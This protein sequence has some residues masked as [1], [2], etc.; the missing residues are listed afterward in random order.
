M[1]YIQLNENGPG[2]AS[3]DLTGLAIGA[4]YTLSFNYWGD[5]EPGQPYQLT[6][7][8]DGTNIFS[9]PT[10]YDQ[11]SGYYGGIGI[12]ASVIFQATQSSEIMTFTG[13][14]LSSAS[15]VIDNIL[16]TSNVPEPEEFAMIL[17]G[18][19]FLGWSMLRKS[20]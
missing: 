12:V 6:A 2:T 5:N 15:P 16:V 20:A 11:S 10:M 14:T 19:P 1:R 18:L 4:N 3:Y 7:S 9:S 17:L 8:V 13:S